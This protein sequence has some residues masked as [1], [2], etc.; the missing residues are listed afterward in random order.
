MVCARNKSVFNMWNS[1]KPTLENP[2][3]PIITPWPCS[4]Q[5]YSWRHST[6][7]YLALAAISTARV[8]LLPRS[9]NVVSTSLR[10]FSGT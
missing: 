4:A 8:T 9:F 10:N 5:N 1:L 2:P 7:T 6:V 3:P